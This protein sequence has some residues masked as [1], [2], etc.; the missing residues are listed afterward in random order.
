MC[1]ATIVW[2]SADFPAFVRPVSVQFDWEQSQGFKSF[3]VTWPTFLGQKYS[4]FIVGQAK[5]Q[6]N[7]FFRKGG[8]KAASGEITLDTFCLVYVLGVS[9]EGQDK[10]IDPQVTPL[11]HAS[12]QGNTSALKEL[13]TGAPIL[14]LRTK[15][16][17]P[18]L[19]MLLSE[20]VNP[21]RR[22]C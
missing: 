10:I 7:S 16:G 3:A 22:F 19:R 17:G 4:R 13:I 21:Q 6:I 12:K 20:T 2:I 5:R 15:W 14:M 8:W 18:R 9:S 1:L 11:M